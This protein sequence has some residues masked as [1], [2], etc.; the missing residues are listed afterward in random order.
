[1][2]SGDVFFVNSGGACRQSSAGCV[3]RVIV[4][5]LP[6]SSSRMSG[7]KKTLP[8]IPS[9]IVSDSVPMNGEDVAKESF[10]Y[11]PDVAPEALREFKSTYKRK[12]DEQYLLEKKYDITFERKHIKDLV[13]L[14]TSE[15]KKKGTKTPML[16]LP[17]RPAHHDVDLKTF[18][19]SV[20]YRGMPVEEQVAKKIIRKTDECILMSALKFLWCRL[21][22]KAIIG[23][24][25]YT[26]FVKLED[27]A[28][29]PDKAFLEFMPN[30]L[31]SGAH[32]S[33]VYDFFDLIVALVLNSK[34][35]LM[36]ARKLS[37]MC[38]LWAFNPVRN[39]A[40]GAPSFERGLYEWIP[41]GDAMYHLLLSFVKAMPP[42]GD[43]TRLPKLFQVLLKSSDY[44][45]LPT[46][47][48]L[49]TSRPL[50]EIPMVT[51]RANTPSANPA[52]LLT[53]V[54]KTL[55]F[56]DATL[57][58]TREDF[59]LLK[60]LFKEK[61]QVVEK[62]SSEG[63]RLLE[64]L[65]LYDSDLMCDGDNSSS[66]K[67][68]L[69]P[70]WS[71]D[72]TSRKLAPSK[73]GVH[74]IFTA[75]IGRA[76][77]DDYFIWTWLA[78]LGVE[79]TD[80]KKKTFGKTYIMEVEL[81][82]G[83]KKWVIV[84]EQDL[85]RDGYDI[86][87]EIKQ[88]KLKQLE[89][90]IQLAEIEAKKVKQ[91]AQHEKKKLVLE[92]VDVK[93]LKTQQPTSLPPPPVPRKDYD[94]D[95]IPPRSKS[96]KPPPQN[97]T[98]SSNVSGSPAPAPTMI[99]PPRSDKRAESP[100]YMEI[101]EPEP[102]SMPAKRYATKVVNNE[103][104]RISLPI[105]DAEDTFLR[106]DA[107]GIS[108]AD[109]QSPSKTQAH[110]YVPAINSNEYAYG[111]G[112]G[113]NRFTNGENNENVSSNGMMN[114]NHNGF[115][116]VDENGNLNYANGVHTNVKHA[117]GAQA[118]RQM[119][120][121]SNGTPSPTNYYSPLQ[122]PENSAAINYE[123]YMQSPTKGQFSDQIYPDQQ[124]NNK[125]SPPP[126]RSPRQKYSTSPVSKSPQMSSSPPRSASPALNMKYQG[127]PRGYQNSPQQIQP[128]RSPIQQQNIQPFVSPN[129]QPALQNLQSPTHQSA[130]QTAQQLPLSPIQQQIPHPVPNTAPSSRSFGNECEKIPNLPP[131]P[132]IGDRTPGDMASGERSES[133]LTALS[134][135]PVINEIDELE[136]EL[137]DCMD[138]LENSSDTLTVQ[139]RNVSNSSR[140]RKAPPLAD[141]LNLSVSS[142]SSSA[143]PATTIGGRDHHTKF[144]EDLRNAPLPAKPNATI[145]GPQQ[146]ILPPKQAVRNS[147]NPNRALSPAQKPNHQLPARH[148]SPQPHHSQQY[149]PQ[150]YPPQQY[151]P[152]QYP[153]QQYPPSG[154]PPQYPPHSPQGYPPQLFP[155]QGYSSQGFPP[156]GFPPPPQ[157]QYPPRQYSPQGY[158][159]PPT[160]FSPRQYPP[161]Q[162]SPRQYPPPQF[163]PNPAGK[164]VSKS[165][166]NQMPP[167][168]AS[169]TPN[170]GKPFPPYPQ[171]VYYP[172]MPP[173]Q[174]GVQIA[175]PSHE[176]QKTSSHSKNI[177]QHLP[178]SNRVDKLHGPQ[179]LNKRNARDAFMTGNFGI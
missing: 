119:Y 96:R 49:E 91:D 94:A 151:P 170:M 9:F 5:L 11:S 139:S 124:H 62:L 165:P 58:Y 130:D 35:N 42:N 177:I 120:T 79:E 126:S 59:L 46:S 52:E 145:D 122:S 113:N 36:S 140:L 108:E 19:N 155:P 164:R 66:L 31:S 121:P 37:K 136:V 163:P 18:L 24:K 74:E 85:E 82:E 123:M 144:S 27:S 14:I 23:W 76:S 57:F 33:I 70:G 109:L 162:F 29:F 173:N 16:M 48:T 77:I 152:Q 10:I 117:N 6:V 131:P 179:N 143:Y 67:F 176:E 128:Q 168:Y 12:T 158:F 73:K 93:E 137:K 125:Q 54:S 115:T 41:A 56:D 178:P 4:L 101:Q 114:G 60:R 40:S 7:P 71:T 107:L 95:E 21:P 160:Q 2:L 43:V 72:M 30:C 61:D 100:H 150:Q 157:Q 20:F 22:G 105:L 159:P 25:A 99:P 106:F 86:E 138:D 68:K 167:H 3:I 127:S 104:I 135:S 34:E 102:Q 38:G 28:G 39:Q 172:P 156:Q 32:A 153:P 110:L 132:E 103:E 171:G 69:V 45:P 92:K 83:F 118:Q 1:M 13:H 65:C 169:P 53:R 129:V 75:V 63:T 17:F 147:S 134:R 112:F 88:E 148:F 81:A 146:G 64:N 149:P 111:N 116:N 87:L 84:E 174:F 175:H 141:P 89:Q 142:E 98:T 166:R 161:Q 154:Y 51:I 50:Q 78:S 44:P 133:E 90:K 26:K 80:L 8:A 47:A 15:I 97:G 55:K